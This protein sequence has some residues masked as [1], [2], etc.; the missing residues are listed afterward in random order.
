MLPELN[1]REFLVPHRMIPMPTARDFEGS[2]DAVR[3]LASL[4]R[5]PTLDRGDAGEG[6]SRLSDM[7]DLNGLKTERVVAVYEPTLGWP[8]KR[9][10]SAA[11]RAAPEPPA[12][13]G[14]VPGPGSAS[15]CCMDRGNCT[16]R[17]HWRPYLDASVQLLRVGPEVDAAGRDV[18]GLAFVAG[19]GNVQQN[20]PSIRVCAVSPDARLSCP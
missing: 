19:E 18:R 20:P 6:F 16:A 13:P 4:R 8:S 12:S 2:A 7:L 9:F 11:S 10:E 3:G 17:G 14:S 15:R 1:A 5:D